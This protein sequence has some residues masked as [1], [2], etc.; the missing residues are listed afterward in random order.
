[1]RINPGKHIPE[2][3]SAVH[4]I[5]DQSVADCPSFKVWLVTLP[6]IL[7]ECDLAGFN[8]NR[9]DIWC[10]RKEGFLQA[11]VDIDMSHRKFVDVQSFSIRW[12][13]VLFLPLISFIVESGGCLRPDTALHTR[14]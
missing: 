14:C 10:W 1:M 9:F 13:N 5:Y 12:S 3:A 4:G 8:S 2:E 11:E 6:M 7:K